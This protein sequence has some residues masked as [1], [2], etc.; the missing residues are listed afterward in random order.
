MGY[1][2][3]GGDDL[4]TAAV[5]SVQCLQIYTATMKVRTTHFI[6]FARPESMAALCSATY[7][8]HTAQL[9]SLR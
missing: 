8:Y 3:G 5:L 7:T 1:G 6:Q 9:L 4:I 2:G